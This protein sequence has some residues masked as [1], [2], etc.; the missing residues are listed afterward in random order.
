MKNVSWVQWFTLALAVINIVVLCI[1]L[2]VVTTIQ[3][4]QADA[5]F[6]VVKKE[7]QRK[8]DAGEYGN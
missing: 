4:H 7:I 3:S 8:L 1:V 5:E 2:S 6:Q